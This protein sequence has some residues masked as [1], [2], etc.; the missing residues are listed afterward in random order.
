MIAFYETQLIAAFDMREQN[1]NKY[2]IGMQGS[3]YLVKASLTLNECGRFITILTHER[4]L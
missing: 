2:I 4:V 1:H 3:R